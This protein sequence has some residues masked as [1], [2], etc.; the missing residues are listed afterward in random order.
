[1]DSKKPFLIF[2]PPVILIII[3]LLFLLYYFF[4]LFFLKIIFFIPAIISIFIYTFYAFEIHNINIKENTENSMDCGCK[5]LKYDKWYI[6]NQYWFNGLGAFIGWI[7]LYI[8]LFYRVD[9]DNPHKFEDI[10]W[11]DFIL[12][13]IAFFGITG[14]FP[15]ASL[16]G[17]FLSK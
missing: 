13:L 6:Y 9:I 17:K 2:I 12:G 1:M 8:L 14:H 16:L 7:A 5:K 15:I 4:S 11:Q 3:L 10:K